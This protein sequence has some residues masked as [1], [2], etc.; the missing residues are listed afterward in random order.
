MQPVNIVVAHNDFITA[1]Q[2]AASLHRHF[3]SVAV[4]RSV[5]EIRSAI[6]KHRPQVALVDLETVPLDEVSRLCQEFHDVSIVCT[7]RV[8]DEEMW[9][10]ALAAGAIDVCQTNDVSAILFAVQ[11]NLPL[12]RASAA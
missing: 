6:P 9:A 12:G 4:A 5:D 10:E 1:A 8:P 3:L 2:L 7:H 11:R